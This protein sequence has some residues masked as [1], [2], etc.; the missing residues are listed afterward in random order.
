MPL[1]SDAQ[2]FLQIVGKL[3][4]VN[5]GMLTPA[6]R[7]EKGGVGSDRNWW[8]GRASPSGTGQRH[9]LQPLRAKG[10]GPQ[11]H[12]LDDSKSQEFLQALVMCQNWTRGLVN[13]MSII[14]NWGFCHSLLILER[15]PHSSRLLQVSLKFSKFANIKSLQLR[16]LKGPRVNMHW[17]STC[18][19]VCLRKGP[20]SLGVLRLQKESGDL[21]RVEVDIQKEHARR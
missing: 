11:C 2:K 18:I 1:S 8:Q 12:P 10:S 17:R 6:C 19:E 20:S 16:G 13:C 21:S 4:S 15:G 5:E 9:C 14:P 3:W 7:G